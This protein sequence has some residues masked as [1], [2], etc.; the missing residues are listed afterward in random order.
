[1]TGPNNNKRIAKNTA[2][3]YCRML[4]L[5][6]V[7]LYTSR[8]VLNTLGVEDFGIYGVVG[9]LVAMAS[10]ITGSLSGSTTRFIT[11]AIGKGDKRELSEIFSTSVTIQLSLIIIV[12]LIAET[13]GIWFLID[14]MVIPQD[15]MWAAIWV[16]QVSI[17]SFCL[18]IFMVPFNSL[19]IAHERMSAFAYISVYDA[20]CKLVIAYL[21]TVAPIDRL[22]WYS[23]LILAVSCSTQLI[24]FVYC[25]K[26]FVMGC[27]C[28]SFNRT[29][30]K[31]MFSFAGWN[32]VG[33]TAAI[34][35]DQ[36][37]NLI[38]NLFS[39]PSVNAARAIAL[40]VNGAVSGFVTNFQTALNPQ[41][42][43]SYAA[44]QLEY[45]RAL[46]QKGAC[47]SYYILLL[48]VL[49]VILKA[50]YIL[51]LWLGIVPEHAVNFL[52][53]I[54][55]FTLCEAISGPLITAM[56][57]TGRIRNYQLFVGGL[58]L[59]NLPVSYIFLCNG[60][61]PESVLIVALVISVLCLLARLMM[62]RKM[63]CL[64]IRRFI[65]EILFKIVIVSVL[66]LILPF[67]FSLY[68]PDSFLY[69]IFLILVSILNT[70]IV[71]YFVGISAQERE[72][73]RIKLKQLISKV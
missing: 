47:Y 46:I 60:Y 63:I 33:T 49:P 16:Y 12:V 72:I 28:L 38:I 61:P 1:M 18:S 10:L 24:Y 67:I 27:C 50:H 68:V 73:V 3:L 13:V 36:G 17:L 14:R 39:G 32:F 52:R 41:I 58:N 42:T 69:F 71:I 26:N 65:K 62:L 6:L 45:M 8:V 59:L 34:L 66:S 22:I 15:R 21:I 19:I 55:L 7:S 9:G 35:R 53:L 51:E 48:L 40:Q 56:L 4:F 44:G 11:I 20:A 37:G 23:L 31:S 70:C 29:R 54:I 25:R 43:K 5:M 2:L 64:S 30:L 57:A